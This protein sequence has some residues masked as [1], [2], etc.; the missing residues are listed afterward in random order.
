MR[1]KRNDGKFQMYVISAVD[2][3]RIEGCTYSQAYCKMKNMIIF[4]SIPVAIF[5]RVITLQM[6]IW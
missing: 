3:Q 2:I 4:T 1:I 6:A 5:W